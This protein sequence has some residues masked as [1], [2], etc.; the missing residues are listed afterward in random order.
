MAR[1]AKGEG[2]IIHVQ[3]IACKA[4]PDFRICVKKDDP[5]NHCSKRD[6]RDRWLYQY[7][8]VGADGKKKKK[9]L[10]A[11]TR[12]AL[13]EKI[14]KLM[15]KSD[16]DKRHEN[17][18]FGNWIDSWESTYLP[19]AVKPSTL[20]F[21][22]S[23]LKHIP[24]NIKKKKLSE[25]RTIDL[26]EILNRLSD[27][28]GVNG[29]G[30]SAKTV[31]SFRTTII[32][33][34]ECAVDN[35][36]LIRNPCKKTKPPRLIQKKI[37]YLTP[38]QAAE[39][40]KV[41]DSGS[42]YYDIQA[43]LKGKKGE[44]TCYLVEM[45]GTLIRMAFATGMRRSELFGLLWANVDLDNK[46]IHVQN[47]M[48]HGK[49][50]ETKTGNSIRNISIDDDTVARL[51][52]FKEQQEQYKEVVGDQYHDSGFV[53]TNSFGNAMN[54]DTFRSRYFSRMC[55]KAGMPE[56]F[57]MHSIR[58]TH[59]TMLLE[60]G[61]SPNVISKRL[62]HSSVAFTLAIYAHVTE[63]M[64]RGAADTIGAILSNKKE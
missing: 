5:G 4:C 42:Y 25:I 30:L 43:A 55:K 8:V 1:R 10:S 27:R 45:M 41:A 61:I 29:Q 14:E 64:E 34:L 22:K 23:L 31:R 36:F 12:K 9:A 49:I 38:E 13:M 32:S 50:T 35:H 57:T 20:Q 62:G 40:Q 11:T 59:A 6:R 63:A 19:H 56:G 37:V 47:G 15:A 3:P 24:E 16:E 2:S 53:F 52:R 17:V 51:I 58:H 26:Q 48:A 21:Y 44:D 60:A 33:C 39:L 7:V 28:G 18:T 46:V 54:F